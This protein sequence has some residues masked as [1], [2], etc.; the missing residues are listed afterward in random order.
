MDY[1]ESPRGLNPR[2]RRAL[3]CIACRKK[4][5]RCDH[6]HPC[7]NCM[8]SRSK[9]C[10]YPGF[11][12][13][14]TVNSPSQG[15]SRNGENTFGSSSGATG[16]DVT[17]RDTIRHDELPQREVWQS[18]VLGEVL[19]T[20]PPGAQPDSGSPSAASKTATPGTVSIDQNENANGKNSNTHEL[21]TNS[22]VYSYVDTYPISGIILKKR[23]FF[24]PTHWIFTTTLVSQ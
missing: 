24:F 22:N 21:R 7:S 3:A 19:V 6:K 16:N 1:G 8:R 9:I 18:S 20:L 13:E 23:C 10:S 17:R 14:P 15:E 2:P 11:Q 4:K 5:L 12:T